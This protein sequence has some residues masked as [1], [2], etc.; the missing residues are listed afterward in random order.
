MAI[1]PRLSSRR[2]L[3]LRENP[4]LFQVEE[5]FGERFDR[6]EERPQQ[7]EAMRAKLTAFE[8]QVAQEGSFWDLPG[9]KP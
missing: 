8:A 7:V 6:A 9:D 2:P 4:L 3:G 5:D 1:D